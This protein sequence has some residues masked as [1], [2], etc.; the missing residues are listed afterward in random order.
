MLA[1]IILVLLWK[2]ESSDFYSATEASRRMY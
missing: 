1:V 2:K